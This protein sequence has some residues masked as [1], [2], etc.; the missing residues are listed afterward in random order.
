MYDGEWKDGL[1]HGRGTFS[2]ANGFVEDAEWKDGKKNGR[3]TF[4]YANGRVEKGIFENDKL[5][6]KL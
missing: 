1:F 2:Y 6:I 5:V 3:G 4:I